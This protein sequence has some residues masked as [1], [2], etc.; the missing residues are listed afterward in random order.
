ME[1]KRSFGEYLRR[2]RLELA[3]TQK[4]LAQRLYVTESTVSKWERGLSYPDVSLVTAIGLAACFTNLPFLVKRDRLP[5]CL[6][7]ATACLILLLVS[8]WPLDYGQREGEEEKIKDKKGNGRPNRPP[9]SFTAWR[10]R[11]LHPRFGPSG[12]HR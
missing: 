1:E 3:M 2:K 8:C 10:F 12:P 4:D 5:V 9:I 11:Y 6:A 7:A